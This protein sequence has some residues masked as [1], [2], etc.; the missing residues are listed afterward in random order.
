[1]RRVH[2]HLAQPGFEY[3]PIVIEILGDVFPPEHVAQKGSRRLGIVRIN[4]GVYRSN[5][6]LLSTLVARPNL[7]RSPSRFGI[8]TR[9]RVTN[10]AESASLSHRFRCA[11]AFSQT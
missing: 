4:Q 1:M 6:V 5:H 10:G 8:R 3:Q 11:E 9:K 2:T 7:V